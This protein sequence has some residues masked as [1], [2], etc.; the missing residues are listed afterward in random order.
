MSSA[1]SNARA[2]YRERQGYADALGRES[3]NLEEAR[4]RAIAAAALSGAG[5]GASTGISLF[6]NSSSSGE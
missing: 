4:K 6:G 3:T 5:T 2:T 1:G